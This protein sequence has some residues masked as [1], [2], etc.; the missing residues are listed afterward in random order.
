MV[1]AFLNFSTSCSLSC[2]QAVQTFVNT[3]AENFALRLKVYSAVFVMLISYATTVLT[4]QESLETIEVEKAA[5][6][7]NI[8]KLEEN[9]LV[10]E[11]QFLSQLI[12]DD[13][14]VTAYE[15][16]KKSCGKWS[17][18]CKTKTGTTPHKLRTV[19]VDPKVVPLGSLLYIEGV[20]WRIAEDI[21][22]VVKGNKIDLFVESR[23]KAFNFGKRKLK[24]YYHKNT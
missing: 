9:I 14:I 21:G 23:D 5:L 2:K 12:A 11:E 6:Q 3:F 1:L 4:F 13:F 15:Q 10:M 20:G 18:Y 17:K 19:A 22:G 7:Q 24:V 8:S 16:S